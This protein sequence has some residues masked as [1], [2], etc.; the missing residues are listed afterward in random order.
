[1]TRQGR[2]ARNR[3]N[4]R[5]STGPKSFE[6]KAVVSQNARRHGATAQPDPEHFA[7]WLRIILDT[8]D[9]RQE[10]FLSKDDRILRACE[11]AEAEVRLANSERALREF[12]IGT[13][14]PDGKWMDV[15]KDLDAVRDIFGSG[16]VTARQRRSGLALIERARRRQDAEMRPDGTRHRL[17][18]RY[19]REARAR[20]KR[21]FAAWVVI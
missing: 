6:G 1:M 19:A 11:L 13:S 10:D 8:P 5:H 7:T 21:A 4:A 20:R 12:E 16:D 15:Q 2:A 14:E 3:A 17:F 18:R 9:L